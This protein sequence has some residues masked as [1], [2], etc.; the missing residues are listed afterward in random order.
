MKRMSLPSFTVATVVA[1]AMAL[2]S[3]AG[4]KDDNGPAHDLPQVLSKLAE[5]RALADD[6]ERLAC[7]DRESGSLISAADKGEVKVIDKAEAKEMR[8]SLFG[9]SLP[10]IALFGGDEDSDDIMQTTITDVRTV[11]G[12]YRL[13]IEEGATWQ[14]IENPYYLRR[15]KAGDP[16]EFKKASFGSYFVRINGQTGVKGYRVN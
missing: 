15:P 9:F 7:Y 14:L 13:T 11:N 3:S 2:G 12:K 4:A 16:V 6:A 1:A 10:K 5:C 8:R